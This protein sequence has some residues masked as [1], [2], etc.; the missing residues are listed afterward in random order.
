MYTERLQV[1]LSPE[2]RRHLES[3]AARRGMSTA[4]LVREALDSLLGVV[5][6][7]DRLE[8]LDRLLGRE[9]PFVAP[10]KLDELIE[11]RFDDA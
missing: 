3:E 2:Q 9:I 1:L 10:E 4:A 5:S 8:A 6:R 7:S 11:S